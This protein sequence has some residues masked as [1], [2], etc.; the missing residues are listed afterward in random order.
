MN[1]LTRI[2]LAV[3]HWV[4]SLHKQPSITDLNRRIEQAQSEVEKSERRAEAAAKEVRKSQEFQRKNHLAELV[5][6]LFGDV[7]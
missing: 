7:R 1:K 2:I 6:E 4:S 3:D 5:R